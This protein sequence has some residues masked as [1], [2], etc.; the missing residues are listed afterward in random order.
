MERR[1][2]AIL[3]ADI[4]GYSRLMGRDEA[5]TLATLKSLHAEILDPQIGEHKGRIF[6]TTGD[7]LLVEFPSVVNAVACAVDV[8]RR[9]LAR[10]AN[11]PDGEQVHLR[12]GVN[13]G[14]VIVEGED[15]LGDGVNIAAR[16]ESIAPA[17]GVMISAT[18]HDHI[19]KR[20]DFAFEDRGEQSLRN[21]DRPVRTYAVHLG[22]P[23]S[24]PALA[25]PDKPS[26]AVLP[27]QNMS[28]DPE[29]EYFADGMVEEV[30]TALSRMKW[31][32]VIAR[33]SSFTYKGR[34]TEVR[35]VGRELGVRY[36]LEGSVRKA[37]DKVRITGQLIDAS[38][39]A[40]IW[41]DRFDG[42][43][44]E[45]FDLQDRITASVVGAIAPKLEQAEIDRARR[46]S[47]DSLDAYDYYLRGI[48]A[49]H[50]W[51][52]KDIDEALPLFFKAIELD[53]N[54]ASAH[55]MAAWCYVLRKANS[56]MLDRQREI[57]ETERLAVRA[58]ELGKDDAVA[59]AR[60][61]HAL[62][63]VVGDLSSG[64]EFIDRA[65][66]LNPNL[67]AAW[68]FSGWV[69]ANLGDPELALDHLAR[70]MRMSPFDPLMFGIQNGFAMA[71]FL[72]KRYLDA[73]SWAEK[74]LRERPD[75]LPSLRFAAA[76]NALMGRLDLA[77]KAVARIRQLDPA[78][79][80][81]SLASVVPFRRPDDLAHL[82]D[83]LR[84]AGLPE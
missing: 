26:I 44:G 14:D 56:W 78:L 11:L 22:P 77:Q 3:A 36:V 50:R 23:P 28:G 10:N 74:S 81:S 2:A 82:A 58:V 62:A 76:A 68:L 16:L 20:L 43:M 52:R 45:V 38:T 63:F 51:A 73:A 67:A 60:A 1:L 66:A 57:E 4:V 17:G 24:R 40:H 69:R 84:V 41:A 27:F 7:G 6:K 42:G 18:V 15:I 46:K 83:G 80:V 49:V 71:H 59:L 35:Q 39:G 29:Q 47:T 34:S 54:F 5:G 37:A 55:G 21:I 13:L 31:L 64:A 53:P 30:I 32:F 61:G 65:L 8:Q 9:M 48:A 79:T 19:G 12:I 33:N 25:L 75:Y 72:A 70:A